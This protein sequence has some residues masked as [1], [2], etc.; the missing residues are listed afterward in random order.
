[1]IKR[2]TVIVLLLWVM[3]TTA[4]AQLGQAVPNTRNATARNNQSQVFWFDGYWWG[5]FRHSDGYWRLFRYFGSWSPYYLFENSGSGLDFADVF[6]DEQNDKLFIFFTKF[7]T[8]PDEGKF[9]RIGYSNGSWSNEHDEVLSSAVNSDDLT[10]SI[11]KANDGDLFIMYTNGSNQLAGHYS[12]DNG[13]TWASFV[14][15]S[16][17]DDG[18]VDAI[19]FRY[20]N[21]NYL[22]V[23]VG[24]NKNSPQFRFFT[25][26]DEDDPSISANWTEENLNTSIVGDNHVNIVK[27]FEQNLYFIGKYGS[28]APPGVSFELF[29]RSAATGNWTSYNVAGAPVGTG[30][31]TRPALS[32]DITNDVLYLFNQ[33]T[34]TNN[35]DRIWVATK[36]T[37]SL[38]NIQSSDW[39]IVM[40]DPSNNLREV[41]APYQ[42]LTSGSDLM[43][44]CENRGISQVW[45]RLLEIDYTHPDPLLISEVNSTSN[46]D[47]SYL[48]IYNNS[49]SVVNLADYT[50]K[51]YNNNSSTPVSSLNLSGNING[52]GRVVVARNSSV[53][54]SVYR[55]SP[56]FEANG[57]TFDGDK[58]GIEL[59]NNNAAALG[60]NSAV[61]VVDLFNNA[62]GDKLSW[63]AG[64]LF[65]RTRFPNDGS[66]IYL[67]WDRSR[68][69]QAGTPGE[70]NDTSLPVHLS[71]FA[72]TIVDHKV[73][74]HW[75]TASE[76]DNLEWLI[77]R[78]S[79]PDG[80]FFPIGSLPGYGTTNE[81]KVYEFEDAS[82]LWNNVY[83]YRL[84]S[85]DYNGTQHVFRQTVRVELLPTV[86][87]TYRL[88][89]NFPNPFN[90]ETNI[91]FRMGEAGVAR[92]AVF[93]ITGQ[94]VKTIVDK[95]LPEGEYIYRWDGTNEFG[96][97]LALGMYIAQF[98]TPRYF[99]SIKM[100]LTK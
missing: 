5:V 30:Q 24:E 18:L 40:S 26:K 27:D 88:Y 59:V 6:I 61:A 12:N 55:F 36:N 74:L 45:Y 77:E 17:N 49:N 90:P 29:R 62:G 28:G 78:R 91:R 9:Y 80:V 66:N 51:Y 33:R 56:D 52:F 98:S 44:V 82:V 34:D 19:S 38:S 43:V 96:N 13:D 20:N 4:L 7:L 67:D 46:I 99:K 73:Q 47:A 31:N 65:E 54:S 58:D 16:L 11:T 15:A 79:I 86:A 57:F 37:N 10:G 25:L 75:E 70:E 21:E 63:S 76:I 94:L 48:E 32:I 69:A 41:S 50:L 35:G 100:M 72:A 95:Y 60:K 89:A 3:G 84:T 8:N 85:I 23:V 14:V 22:G 81:R 68:T 53:F 42:L 2:C 71:L 64:Q 1:M 39:Y 97:R 93:D 92:L 83:E 87:E